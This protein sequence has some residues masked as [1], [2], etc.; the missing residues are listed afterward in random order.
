M[1]KIGFIDYYISE[2]HANHYPEWI[3]NAC[4]EL[5]LDYT[6]AY[7]WAELDI[8]PKDGRSTDEWCKTYGVEKCNTIEELC[9]KSDFIIILAPSDPDKH[10]AYAE[11]ALKFGKRTYIDK[12]FAADFASS[13][14]IFEAGNKGKTAFFSSS[15][16]RF[17]S[18]IE[19]LTNSDNVIITGGGSNFE[20]YFIHQ[21]EIAVKVLQAKSVSGQ[22][23]R[24]GDQIIC[25]VLFENG[26]HATFLYAKTLP[27]TI[28]AEKQG[29]SI[30]R[31][32]DSDYFAAL[33]EQILIFFETGEKP[34]PQWQTKEIMR[35]RER[36][37]KSLVKTDN[38]SVE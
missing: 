35:I 36:L 28:C 38:K 37:L 10:L 1:K 30:Y 18:E 29:K 22:T 23:E 7:A 26:K 27:F 16:L 5:G 21:A 8:S 2:W 33:I 13:E 25:N 12:T 6:V 11:T 14:K 17:A 3:K 9:E 4:S 20:E 32:I 31:T 24:H 15:A 34:F 19:D